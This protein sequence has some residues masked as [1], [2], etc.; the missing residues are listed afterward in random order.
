[1][2]KIVSDFED[3]RFYHDAEVQKALRHY[4]KH[5]MIRAL[6]QF[7]F[8]EASMEEI[9]EKVLACH[10]IRDFQSSVIYLSV[11]K[12]LEK[13]S[14][15][16]TYSGF[17][18]LEKDEAYLFISNHRD[19]I[20]DTSLLNCVLFETD[21]IMTASAIGDN[22]VQKPFLLAL[23]RLNRNFLVRRGLGPREM[24]K[25]SQN[26]S[27]YI[28]SLLLEE[29][30]S[31]WMAQREGRTKDGDDQ[32]QQGVL[33]M[34]AMAK[35]EKSLAEYFSRL[36]IVPVSISYEFDPTDILKMPELLAK[37]MEKIY[38]KSANEDFASIL[39]GAMGQK[40]RIHISAAAPIDASVLEELDGISNSV[41]DQ[42]QRLTALIDERIHRNYKLWPSNYI[43]CDLLSGERDYEKYYTSK[44]KRQF[45][46]R[47]TKRVDVRNP[48]AVN[49]Y[50]LMY[51]NPV[52]NKQPLHEK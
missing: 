40:G 8:P 2:S 7:T 11:Q 52:L 50:L 38:V 10:S 31:V 44:K 51:A 13:S 26:L 43:A 35:G 46:R 21:L 33:K 25:S 28:K 16:L 9:K 29:N 1:M 27:E 3:I 37:R 17:D 41:N 23:S 48:L 39:K 45:E 5:P 6:L 22:L 20:L 47:I 30:R 36:K 32:T 34:L 42:L 4:L 18:K 15:G 12:V 19:I 24:L 14:E 49:S